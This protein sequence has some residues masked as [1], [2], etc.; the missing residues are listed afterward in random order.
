MDIILTQISIVQRINIDVHKLQ[1]LSGKVTK[2]IKRVFMLRPLIVSVVSFKEIGYLV[3][4]QPNSREVDLIVEVFELFASVFLGFWM[5]EIRIVDFTWPNVSQEI[6]AT[7]IFY[8]DVFCDAFVVGLVD[9]VVE[10]LALS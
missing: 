10:L 9:L 4:I 6:V 8:K 1:I 5:E 7:Y 3:H 2:I